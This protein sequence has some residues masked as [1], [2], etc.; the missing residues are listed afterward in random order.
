MQLA[1]LD[2]TV[3]LNCVIKKKNLAVKLPLKDKRGP[4][5]GDGFSVTHLYLVLEL[6]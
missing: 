6:F 2:W 1:A 5:T 4:V 3:S